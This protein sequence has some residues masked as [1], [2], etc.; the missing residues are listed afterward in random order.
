MQAKNIPNTTTLRRCTCGSWEAHWVNLAGASRFP[1]KC[2]VYG[3]VR[4]D[5]KGAHVW[6]RYDETDTDR[7]R[8]IIALC[9]K[10]NHRS[11]TGWQDVVDRTVGEPAS[12]KHC[13]KKR[14]PVR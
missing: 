3:C 12:V 7:T 2:S 13:P 4:E 14:K 8:Y 1:S 9:S 6:L 11:E 10:H 5:V